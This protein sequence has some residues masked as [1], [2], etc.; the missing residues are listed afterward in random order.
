MK[1][2]RFFLSILL[3]LTA[4]TFV[5]CGDSGKIRKYTDESV[6]LKANSVKKGAS[7]HQGAVKPVK[8]ASFEWDTPDGWKNG[9]S[10][11]RI[12]LA[13]LIIKDEK[14]KVECTIIPL[15]GDGGG[16]EPNVKLWLEQI[17][18]MMDINGQDFKDFIGKSKKFKTKT[19]LDVVK[20]DASDLVKESSDN[21]VLV[22]IIKL[23][24]STIFIKLKGKKS[25]LVKNREKFRA[26][27][28]SFRIKK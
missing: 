7:Q 10:T 17:G 3:L 5:S 23:E 28:E 27:S 4:L 22:S 9:T 26:F 12:R 14:D 1:N 6:D 11:S 18:I 24:T 20:I 2:I 8:R 16:F 13:T 15:M 19:G 21:S 25:I